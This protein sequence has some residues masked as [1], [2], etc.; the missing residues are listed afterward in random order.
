MFFVFYDVQLFYFWNNNDRSFNV[1]VKEDDKLIFY[2]YSVVQSIDVIRGK[3]GYIRGLYVWQITWVMRQRGIYV[4][5][6]V[7]IVDVFL[8]FVGYTI[9]VGNNYEFWGWDLGR[10]R[11]YYDGKNQLSKIYSVFLELDEI[12]IVFDFFLVVLD[13]DDGILS[14]IV[15]GQ[16][17]G[18]VFRGFKGKKFYFVVSVVWGYCEIRMRYLNGFDRKCFLYFLKW[19]CF[20]IYVCF[21]GWVIGVQ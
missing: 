6:G 4:V 13:M 14:F 9:F 18:V 2:R 8:Y 17:M 20:Q 10:N 5:V 15:D 1:F 3:V 11:F 16:Y 21:C 19:Q 12:F 7:A